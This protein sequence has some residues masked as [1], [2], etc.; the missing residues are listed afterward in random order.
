MHHYQEEWVD[1]EELR[2]G[3]EP[4]PE[5]LALKAR[6][7]SASLRQ[8]HVRLLLMFERPGQTAD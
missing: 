3:I 7:G 4:S 2:I 1:E 6:H 5:V 8:R